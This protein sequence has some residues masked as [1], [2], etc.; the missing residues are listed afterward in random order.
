MSINPL[1]SRVYEVLPNSSIYIIYILC[2]LATT[3][4]MPMALG[5]SGFIIINCFRDFNN[6]YL[7]YILIN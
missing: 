6:N 4:Q 3:L 2:I 7:M 1:I 5:V